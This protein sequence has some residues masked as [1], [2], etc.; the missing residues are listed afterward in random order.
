MEKKERIGVLTVDMQDQFFWGYDFD[1]KIRFV[2]SYVDFLKT[3]GGCLRKES[4][5]FKEFR[6][7]SPTFSSIKGSDVYSCE[8]V[9]SNDVHSAFVNTDL[10]RKVKGEEISDLV[11]GGTCAWLC[12]MDTVKGALKR[13]FDVAI[14]SYL[15]A[16]TSDNKMGYLDIYSE[17]GARILESEYEVL[18]YVGSRNR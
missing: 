3:I 14:P 2:R 12:V 15:V 17:M 5:W 13:G 6:G 11:V 16:S 4:F 1:D 18:D 10:E 9:V 7:S 8:R